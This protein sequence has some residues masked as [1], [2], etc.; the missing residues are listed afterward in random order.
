MYWIRAGIKRA[1]IGQSRSI[2]IPQK[3]YENHRKISKVDQ[4]LRQELGRSGTLSEVA[5]A[6]GISTAQVQRC[7]LALAQQCFSLDAQIENTLKP[8]SVSDR[9]KNT[10][11][12]LVRE[13]PDDHESQ[14]LKQ[15]SLKD[16]LI[17][18]LS[19][20]L[21]PHEVDL[22]S[23]RFG[24]ID[25]R[26][27]PLGYSGPL[28]IAQVSKLVGMKPDKVR[29]RINASLRQLR[30]LIADEWNNYEREMLG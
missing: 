29:R 18:T 7:L 23:L 1:Q 20:I 14:Y 30:S 25:E 4:E 8:G 26:I 13:K 24:L 6:A 27:V 17:H 19:R 3:L 5:N 11:Y 15:Q 2:T 10:L 21:T 16:E 22:L 12:D 9:R 28:S